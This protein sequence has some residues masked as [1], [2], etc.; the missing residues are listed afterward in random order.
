MNNC[1]CIDSDDEDDFRRPLM[2]AKFKKS[3][4]YRQAKPRDK[5]RNQFLTQ[6]FPPS[7]LVHNGLKRLP[8]NGTLSNL[9]E[10]SEED[11]TT[12]SSVFQDGQPTFQFASPKFL[13]LE[14]GEENSK[15][16][17]A[18]APPKSKK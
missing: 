18:S 9:T 10:R 15:N 17:K 16:A 5:R 7:P 8:F 2:K 11:S 1:C 3:N 12:V 4:L 6:T 13:L 14:E